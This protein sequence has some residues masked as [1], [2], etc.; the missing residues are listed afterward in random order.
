MLDPAGRVL[1]PCI[2]NSFLHC[3]LIVLSVLNLARLFQIVGDT[4]AAKKKNREKS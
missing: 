3:L 1:N 4:V 2:I